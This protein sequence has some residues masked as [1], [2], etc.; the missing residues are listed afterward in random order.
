MGAGEP[1]T[2][3]VFMTAASPGVIAYFIPNDYYPDKEAY[4]Y[5]LSEGM[6]DEYKAIVDAGILLQID[7]PDLAMTRVSQFSDLTNEEFRKVVEMH[8][9]VLSYALK[10]LSPERMRMHLCWG[11]TEGPHNH[12][13]P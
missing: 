7:C 9:E 13:I 6:K 11:N 10:G 8:I 2:E 12:D 5:A 1:R 3:E 4:L